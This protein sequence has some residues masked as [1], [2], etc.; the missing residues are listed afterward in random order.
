MEEI[1]NNNQL[2]FS[3]NVSS[4]SSITQ[5][6]TSPDQEPD[7]EHICNIAQ[8]SST[9]KKHGSAIKHINHALSRIKHG[10]KDIEKMPLHELTDDLAGKVGTYMAVH[11]NSYMKENGKKISLLTALS[12][13]STFKQ[14]CINRFRY[15]LFLDQ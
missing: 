5:E 11:A 9:T 6:S 15:V 12:Y 8:G 10:C 1:V 4:L 14:I 7:F 3:T 13:M 2:E